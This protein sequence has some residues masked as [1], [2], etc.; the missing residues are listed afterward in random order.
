MSKRTRSESDD[1][2]I[3]DLTKEEKETK[4]VMT[5]SDSSLRKPL[6]SVDLFRLYSFFRPYNPTEP[7]LHLGVSIQEFVQQTSGH[8]IVNVNPKGCSHYVV[9]SRMDN[10]ITIYDPLKKKQ[11]AALVRAINQMKKK[12]KESK[13]QVQSIALGWQTNGWECGIF[14]L[15]IL[16]LL[17]ARS[18]PLP[19]HTLPMP[20]VFSDF[21]LWKRPTLKDEDVDT[22]GNQVWQKITKMGTDVKLLPKLIEEL[23][24]LLQKAKSVK[25]VLL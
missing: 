14:C 8:W 21:C 25:S 9:A 2:L 15:W 23:E 18:D 12:S 16:F 13:L 1:Y 17:E 20:S 3:I 19:I 11:T 10:L 7:R 6:C 5:A 24:A 22:V 4:S